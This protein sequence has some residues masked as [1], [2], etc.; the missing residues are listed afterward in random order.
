MHCGRKDIFA[1]AGY[2]FEPWIVNWLFVR[3]IH[4]AHPYCGCLSVSRLSALNK[5][6]VVEN[7]VQLL[8]SLQFSQENEGPR[9][10]ID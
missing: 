8:N 10:R 2:C 9:T 4:P 1:S 7:H 6:G 5:S 3:T